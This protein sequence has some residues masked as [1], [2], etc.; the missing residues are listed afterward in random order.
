MA[1]TSGNWRWR[2]ATMRSNCSATAPAS[3][4]DEDG[5]DGGGHHLG[6]GA[7]HLGESISRQVDP[8]FLPGRRD[9][10]RGDGGVEAQVVIGDHQSHTAKAPGAQRAQELGSEGLV[11][12]VARS[13]SAKRRD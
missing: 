1:A 2:V 3:G 6:L 7:G 9:E 11:L 13:C 12:S 5:A 4:L 10:H 8:T